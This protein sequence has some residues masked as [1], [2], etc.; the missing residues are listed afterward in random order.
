MKNLLNSPSLELE[1]NIDI[2]Y[3]FL[4]EPK[5]F[6]DS[7][8]ENCQTYFIL[9]GD[10]P[11][12]VKIV[13]YS[14]EGEIKIRELEVQCIDEIGLIEAIEI[15]K[16]IELVVPSISIHVKDFTDEMRETILKNSNSPDMD[17]SED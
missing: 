6:I 11:T 14:S 13:S 1:T 15:H 4:S 10:Y 16:K 5:Y 2:H 12:C 8:G 3:D 9:I 17:F 7:D